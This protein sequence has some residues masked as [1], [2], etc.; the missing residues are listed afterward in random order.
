MR[1]K[2]H[3]LKLTKTPQITQGDDKKF[4]I[5]IN[6]PLLPAK[7]GSSLISRQVSPTLG[8]VIQ[9]VCPQQSLIRI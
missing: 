4:L 9:I 7:M 6:I 5:S 8:R 3:H 2:I 1:L